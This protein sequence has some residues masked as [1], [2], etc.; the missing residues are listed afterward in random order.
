MLQYKIRL[1]ARCTVASA[2]AVGALLTTPAQAQ[3]AKE[4]EN[5]KKEMTRIAEER[6][7]RIRDLLSMV[8]I[9]AR[10]DTAISFGRVEASADG[11]VIRVHNIVASE[12]KAPVLQV[13]RLIE[14]RDFDRRHFIPRAM[15]ITSDS[16]V[17][18]STLPPEVQGMYRQLRLPHLNF[19]STVE[20]RYD[21][22]K[23]TLSL[24][25]FALEWLGQVKIEL[26]A[27]F[28]NFPRLNFLLEAAVLG[29]NIDARMQQVR[30]RTLRLVLTGRQVHIWA[31]A[32]F[33]AFS[34]ATP[35]QATQQLLAI[36]DQRQAQAKNKL[37][38]DMAGA[39]KVM[40]KGPGRMTVT[41]TG[42]P[43]IAV[44][45]FERIRSPEEA[46]KVLDIKIAAKNG[47]G[48][49]LLPGKLPEAWQKLPTSDESDPARH[50]C[51]RHAA[52]PADG[53]KK[54]DGVPDASVDRNMAMVACRRATLEYP[55]AARFQYQYGRALLLTGI[56]PEARKWLA[57]AAENGYDAARDLLKKA[58]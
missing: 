29:R 50:E 20:F 26:S 52:H 3:D 14:L 47:K 51:D 21:E 30:F 41:V 56:V 11:E 2:V 28:Q 40:L 34:G 4:A 33:G 53:A 57:R 49:D 35:A 6:A 25:T 18:A 39:L 23:K 55:K 31:A 5:L 17:L 46:M 54:V 27:E 24:K 13:M 37:E 58:K 43:T 8:A 32:A 9:G 10:K 12:R 36:L 19:F 1:L 44:G 22:A 15:R 48:E 45:H 42:K 7:S 16:S 38:S